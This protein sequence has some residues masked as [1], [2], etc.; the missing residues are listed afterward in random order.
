VHRGASLDFAD[1]RAYVP[2]DQP[3]RV[4]WNIFNRS[5][6]LFVKQFDDEELLTVHLLLDTS[7]SMDWGEPNKLVY[8][9]RL[10][11]ALGYIALSGHSRLVAS[12]LGERLVASFGP[13]WGRGQW[14]GLQAFLGAAPAERGTDLDAALAAHAR[15]RGAPGLAI[16]V[17]DLLTPHWER[18]VKALLAR[19]YEVVILHLLAPQEVHPA[20]SGD[21]QLHDRESGE[22]VDVTLNQDALDRY[23]ERYAAWCRHLESFC[24]RY[25][26]L[27]HRIETVE[28]LD[29]VLFTSLRRRG[30]LQ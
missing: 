11:G 18:G 28:P 1:Y 16:L 19:R 29:R 5:G 4:D 22:R 12:T 9:R 20:M 17:S 27:Y 10:V 25:G 3:E 14:R 13:A 8:A 21:L 7:R 2:G 6:A 30:V 26:V 15:S 23:H 24:G